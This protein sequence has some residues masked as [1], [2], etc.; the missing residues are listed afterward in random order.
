MTFRDEKVT[1]TAACAAV[2]CP[3]TLPAGTE[4]WRRSIKV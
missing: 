4:I 2:L 1:T 3:K